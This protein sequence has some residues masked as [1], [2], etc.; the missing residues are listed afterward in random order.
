MLLSLIE[1]CNQEVSWNAYP[2]FVYRLCLQKC[3]DD[4]VTFYE[5]LKSHRQLAHLSTKHVNICPKA[6]FGYILCIG[7]DPSISF[8][9]IIPELACSARMWYTVKHY[10]L[11]VF[12]KP[13]AIHLC[14]SFKII[15]CC[16]STVFPNFN[17]QAFDYKTS[18][19]MSN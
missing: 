14:S 16:C 4:E 12:Q 19:T 6:R 9:V 7:V 2:F 1:Y 13:S 15:F 10:P 17:H 11:K 18:K 8:H 3:I 5:A